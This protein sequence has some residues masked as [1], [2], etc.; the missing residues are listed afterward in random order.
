M[1]NM[2]GKKIGG[3]QLRVDFLRTQSSRRVSWYLLNLFISIFGLGTSLIE[4]P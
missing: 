3:D 1:K 2:N 4:L